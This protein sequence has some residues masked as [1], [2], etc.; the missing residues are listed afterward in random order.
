MAT[1]VTGA[2]GCLSGTKSLPQH[3]QGQLLLQSGS[4]RQS[5]S[6]LVL[7]ANPTLYSILGGTAGTWHCCALGAD[8]CACPQ[9]GTAQW[10]VPALISRAFQG[11]VWCCSLSLAHTST[12]PQISWT[13]LRSTLSH[14]TYCWLYWG[15]QKE[16]KPTPL[17]QTQRGHGCL[18]CPVCWGVWR[19]GKKDAGRRKQLGAA[20]VF[21]KNDEEETFPFSPTL[22]RPIRSGRFAPTPGG[23]PC[24]RVRRAAG[25]FQPHTNTPQEIGGGSACIPLSLHPSLVPRADPAATPPAQRCDTSA[26]TA[27]APGLAHCGVTEPGAASEPSFPGGLGWRFF[28]F[29]KERKFLLNHR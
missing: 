11:G 5:C 4:Q 17:R 18:S 3:K 8:P 26:P 2:I 23:Q 1:L 10:G 19:S 13:V 6:V 14:Q 22:S 27:P 28:F 9:A 20:L 24:C 29:L 21:G 7:G 15:D 16:P 12:S 25:I